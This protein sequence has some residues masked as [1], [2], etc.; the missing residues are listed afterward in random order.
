MK[1]PELLFGFPPI[2]T[3]YRDKLIHDYD[4]EDLDKV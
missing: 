4:D 2:Y 1:F 3:R